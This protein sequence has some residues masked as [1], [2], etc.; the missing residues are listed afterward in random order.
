M[1][2]YTQQKYW[3]KLLAQ[4]DSDCE[5]NCIA[6]SLF[7][8]RERRQCYLDCDCDAPLCVW[9]IPSWAIILSEKINRINFSSS[10]WQWWPA[11]IMTPSKIGKVYHILA[12]GWKHS[13]ISKKMRFLIFITCLTVTA[14]SGAWKRNLLGPSFV[15]KITCGDQL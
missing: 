3:W 13:L 8:N 12:R 10:R 14:L 11:K 7:T 6:V 2:C 5:W 15:H 9:K 4:S 1:F